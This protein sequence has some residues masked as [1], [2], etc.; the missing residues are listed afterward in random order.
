MCEYKNICNFTIFG[1][2]FMKFSPNCRAKDIGNVI[3]YFGK[4]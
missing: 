1:L 3:D 4:F 2:I